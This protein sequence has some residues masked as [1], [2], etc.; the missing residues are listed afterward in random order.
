MAELRPIIVFQGRHL[1]HHLGICNPNCV[2]LLQAMSGVIPRNLKKTASLPQTAF[3][4]STNAAYKQT[5]TDTDTHVDSNRR[6][7]MRCISPE[8]QRCASMEF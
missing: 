6:N 3:L 2:K 4:A 8:N 1:V 5:N 7:A